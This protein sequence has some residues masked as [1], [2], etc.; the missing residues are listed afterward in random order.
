MGKALTIPQT[1]A[2]LI[3]EISE[4]AITES[5]DLQLL[6]DSVSE[7]ELKN[8][9]WFITQIQNWKKKK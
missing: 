5:W 7:Q 1:T 8:V 2:Q 6:A 3:R 4:R 9:D